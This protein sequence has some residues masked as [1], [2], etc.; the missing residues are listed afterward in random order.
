MRAYSP[1]QARVKRKYRVDPSGGPL[2]L[3]CDWLVKL[4]RSHAWPVDCEWCNLGSA[5]E[6]VRIV[7]ARGGYVLGEDSAKAIQNAVA[8]LSREKDVD[9]VYEWD[10]RLGHTVY[11]AGSY[12]INA[13]REI[14][15]KPA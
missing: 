8:V 2:G 12:Y 15:R 11:L 1:E 4:L 9:A 14:R 6:V 10:Y 5:Y 13:R 7:P 3:F